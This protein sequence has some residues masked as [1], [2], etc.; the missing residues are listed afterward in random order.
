MLP[1]FAVI[2]VIPVACAVAR[3]VLLIVATLVLDEFHV[4]SPVISVVVPSVNVPI[5][6]NCPVPSERIEALFGVTAI[7]ARFAIV[8]LTL[9]V[10][11]RLSNAAVRV[12]VPGATPVTSPVLE[13][14]ASLVS[15]E[16]QS[17]VLVIV[18]VVPSL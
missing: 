4:T 3:P 17:T 2:L 1:E 6:L 7:D 14:V 11:L 5:A 18:F 13:T 12:T 15:E 8:T 10:P 16:D 9:V